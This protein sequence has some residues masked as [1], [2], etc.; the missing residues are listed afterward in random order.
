MHSGGRGGELLASDASLIIDSV[1]YG[2][3]C[4][5]LFSHD[6]RAFPSEI[7]SIEALQLRPDGSSPGEWYQGSVAVIGANYSDCVNVMSG[8]LT[9]GGLH[10]GL[11]DFIRLAAAA[12]LRRVAAYVPISDAA[13]AASR[14]TF[15]GSNVRAASMLP[16]VAGTTIGNMT[17]LAANGATLDSLLQIAAA[18]NGTLPPWNYSAVPYS[19]GMELRSE[20]LRALREIGLRYL[21]QGSSFVADEYAAAGEL[22]N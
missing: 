12:S 7:V 14:F 9:T 8:S 6:Y 5:A 20:G 22:T 16:V 10:A 1:L 15:A 2:N 17:T 18:S 11:R 19:P 3:A 4:A 21:M 13:R